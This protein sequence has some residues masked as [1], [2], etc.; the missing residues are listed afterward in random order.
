MENN[1]KYGLFCEVKMYLHVMYTYFHCNWQSTS[2][3]HDA[4][5]P[6]QE[7][8]RLQYSRTTTKTA[9]AR[10]SM[11]L[12]STKPNSLKKIRLSKLSKRVRLVKNNFFPLTMAGDLG[13]VPA[14]RILRC[15]ALLLSRYISS[16]CTRGNERFTIVTHV[17]RKH[18]VSISNEG[19]EEGQKEFQL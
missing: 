4:P 9:I 15:R 11:H 3:F 5:R 18:I 14:T 19:K 12:K 7:L 2:S 13:G 17:I 10:V 6:S 1:T 16:N 8:V